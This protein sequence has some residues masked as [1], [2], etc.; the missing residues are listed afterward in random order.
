MICTGCFIKRTGRRIDIQNVESAFFIIIADKGRTPSWRTHRIGSVEN[1]TFEQITVNDIRRPYGSYIGGY[2]DATGVY[3][4]RNILFKEVQVAFK[5]GVD[6][7]P[8]E[9]EEYRLMVKCDSL[10][11]LFIIFFNMNFRNG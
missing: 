6:V 9:P 1:I 8:K 11:G 10:C 3:S 2:Q 7:I 5:G 4:V